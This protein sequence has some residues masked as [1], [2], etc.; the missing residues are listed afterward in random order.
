MKSENHKAGQVEQLGDF[1]SKRRK[2][3]RNPQS[4]GIAGLHR[5]PINPRRNCLLGN[6]LSGR[7]EKLSE[8]EIQ[9]LIEV[10][11]KSRT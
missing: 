7:G 2:K 8:N 3:P 5:E 1:N 10:S 9:K 4:F 11:E 6:L